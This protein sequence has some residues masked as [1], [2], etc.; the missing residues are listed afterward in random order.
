MHLSNLSSQF[1][2]D[3][4][5]ERAGIQFVPYEQLTVTVFKNIS[6]K[7]D[8]PERIVSLTV[9]SG[10]EEEQDEAAVEMEEEEEDE[11][12]LGSDGE[13][14]G[15]KVENIKTRERRRGTEIKLLGL[16]LGEQTATVDAK[17]ISVSLKCNR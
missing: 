4:D 12:A 13:E 3:V 17:Q 5:L 11:T 15:Q 6:K 1:K 7:S 9:A 16:K 2:K 14:G 8:T 10:G